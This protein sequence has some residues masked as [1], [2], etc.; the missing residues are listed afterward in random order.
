M[1]V[2]SS[3]GQDRENINFRGQ[4]I[5]FDLFLKKDLD[6]ERSVR[7]SA[8]NLYSF[9]KWSDVYTRILEDEEEGFYY[10]RDYHTQL[11]PFYQLDLRD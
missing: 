5:G 8:D 4:G 11:Q 2:N 9:I 6:K 10:F 1:R 7:F 3:R